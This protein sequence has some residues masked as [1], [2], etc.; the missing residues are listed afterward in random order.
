MCST[1]ICFSLICI[2]VVDPD[3]HPD[4]HPHQIKI[5]I[6]I[7]IHIKVIRW[8]RNQIRIRIICRSRAKMYGSEPILALFKG[9][10][11]LFGS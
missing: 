2:S 11:P 10:E 5:R 3:S 1:L 7:R 6:R 4:P 9:F 8:I